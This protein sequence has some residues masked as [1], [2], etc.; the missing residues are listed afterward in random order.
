MKI[1]ILTISELKPHEEV[2]RRRVLEVIKMIKKA[3]KFTEPILVEKNTFVILDGHHRVEAMKILGYKK[4]PAK[5]VNYV[6]VSVSL[7]R[8]NLPSQIIK[9]V[10][11]YLAS[12]NIVLPQKTTRHCLVG[13]KNEYPQHI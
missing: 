5:L 10:V 9:E 1:K 2:S 8:K 6:D 4:I 13:I 3:G 7:R 11:L 12:K